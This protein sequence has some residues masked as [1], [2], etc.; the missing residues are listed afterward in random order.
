MTECLLK[1]ENQNVS[2][3][4]L[5]RIYWLDYLVSEFYTEI[6]YVIA[7]KKVDIFLVL[8]NGEIDSLYWKKKKTNYIIPT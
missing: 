2:Y 5:E 3:T 8:F 1:F 6:D 7:T 4:K